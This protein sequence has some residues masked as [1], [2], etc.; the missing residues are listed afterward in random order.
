M[1]LYSKI[2]RLS[3]IGLV[4]F[5]LAGCGGEPKPD[6]LPQLYP[7]TLTF[8]QGGEPCAEAIVTL[9]PESGSP[10]G[11]GGVTNAN[12][13]V[14]VQ[15]HGKFPGAPAGKYKIIVSKTEN[16]TAGQAPVD[17]FTPQ[18]VQTFNLI[19]PIYANSATTILTLEVESSKTK[20][21]YPSFDLGEKVR[22]AV[23]LPGM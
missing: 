10:W 3:L 1:S 15:T 16:G 2:A 11:T 5:V 8:M 13:S 7:V 17:M 18:M 9:V 21:P 22:E 4:A 12:G 20:K 23:R 14:A 19:D 6:G